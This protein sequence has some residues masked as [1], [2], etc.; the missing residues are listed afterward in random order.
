MFPA[1]SCSIRLFAVR[2]AKGVPAVLFSKWSDNTI[3]LEARQYF[4][5]TEGQCLTSLLL[6]SLENLTLISVQVFAMLPAEH[7]D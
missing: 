6:L 2:H 5:M 7:G 1:V 4:G 3:S